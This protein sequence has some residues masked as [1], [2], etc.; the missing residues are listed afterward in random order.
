M[1]YFPLNIE[2][3]K[4]SIL[5]IGGGEVAERKL[6]LLM[7]AEA[8]VTLIA[9]SFTDYLLSFKKNKN[10]VF[11]NSEYSVSI[12]GKYNFSFIKIRY[13]YDLL[14]EAN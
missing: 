3:S 7:K 1:K 10:L 11:I 5:L 6:D 4:K 2:L 9:P 14:L 8:K 12:L 13:Y